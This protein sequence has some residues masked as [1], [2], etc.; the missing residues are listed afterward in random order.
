MPSTWARMGGSGLPQYAS[1]LE[2]D[3][4]AVRAYQVSGWSPWNGDGCV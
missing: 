4:I 2:Q 1:V 3:T